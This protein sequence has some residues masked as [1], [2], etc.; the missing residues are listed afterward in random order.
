MMAICQPMYVYQIEFRKNLPN[1]WRNF[2]GHILQ[3]QLTET[4]PLEFQVNL[5]GIDEI[6]AE[7]TRGIALGGES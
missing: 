7:L 4:L 1:L 6:K 3:P 2:R 5:P